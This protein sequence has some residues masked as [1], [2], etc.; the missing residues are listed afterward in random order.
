MDYTTKQLALNGRM[1]LEVRLGVAISDFAASLDEQR[2]QQF[3]LLRTASSKRLAGF[4]VIRITEDINRHGS[5]RHRSWRAH[6]T[7]IGCFLSRVQRFACIGDMLIG[8][9]QHLIATGVWCAVRF[10]LMVH[11]LEFLCHEMVKNR[12]LTTRE[13]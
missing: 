13:V 5:Q 6:G 12:S 9:S 4:D 8:G 1:K 10:C 7:K 11:N 3:R 2:R